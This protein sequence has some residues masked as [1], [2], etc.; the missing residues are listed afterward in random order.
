[1]TDDKVDLAAVKQR[2]QQ[3]WS[4]GD[5]AMIG[6]ALAIVGENLAERV[7]LVPGERIL[8]VAC[9]S[10]TAT[11][12]AARRLADAVGVDY[13]PALLERGRERAAAER[14]EIEFVEGDAVQLPFEDESFDV[15][16]VAVKAG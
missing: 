7:D 5:F 11:I 16:L 6:G 1:M 13:V 4:E 8:D 12:P 15:V 3:V 10:G 9:G 14:L 2:Q